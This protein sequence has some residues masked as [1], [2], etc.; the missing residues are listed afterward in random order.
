MMGA[1]PLGSGEPAVA[2]RARSANA[3][4]ESSSLKSF[5][6]FGLD[7]AIARAIA[8]RKAR[9]PGVRRASATAQSFPAAVIHDAQ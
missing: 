1:G 4:T 8:K 7:D 5:D 3:Q 9:H 2:R 6:G